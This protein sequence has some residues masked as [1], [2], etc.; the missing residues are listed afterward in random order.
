M[1]MYT[2]SRKKGSHT[3]HA[4]LLDVFRHTSFLPPAGVEWTVHVGPQST[5]PSRQSFG[6]HITDF[7]QLLSVG[8]RSGV[9]TLRRVDPSADAS[10]ALESSLFSTLVDE[11]RVR[12]RTRRPGERE[13]VCEA[14]PVAALAEDICCERRRISVGA[15][16][17]TGLA[18]SL[19][20]RGNTC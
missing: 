17:S 16:P 1:Y 5:T 15:A 2:I 6:F 4:P 11:L 3:R 8:P 9:A 10:T 19:V 12:R 14:S 13:T 18:T 7:I 20:C